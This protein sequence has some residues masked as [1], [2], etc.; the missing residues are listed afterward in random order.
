MLPLLYFAATVVAANHVGDGGKVQVTQAAESLHLRKLMG[1]LGEN[2]VE[3]HNGLCEFSNSPMDLISDRRLGSAAIDRGNLARAIQQ[4]AGVVNSSWRQQRDGRQER[5]IRISCSILRRTS[6]LHQDTI[7]HMPQQEDGYYKT[8]FVFLETNPNAHFSVAGHSFPVVKGNMLVFDGSI[9]HQTVI[10]KGDVKLLGPFETRS[11][12][13]VGQIVSNNPPVDPFNILI[14]SIQGALV[15][16][17]VGLVI[18]AIVAGVAGLVAA[19]AA[20]AAS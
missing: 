18:T 14:W 7:H 16:G 17:L 6:P 12:Q 3:H 20:A 15:L 1:Q 9:P 13:P 11:F 2:G 8:A 10:D 4:G 19:G 5:N